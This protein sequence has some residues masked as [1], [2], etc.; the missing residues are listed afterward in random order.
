VLDIGHGN[1]HVRIGDSDLVEVQTIW[2]GNGNKRIE[3]VGSRSTINLGVGDSVIEHILG[4]AAVI[5]IDGGNNQVEFRP[6]GHSTTPGSAGSV[7]IGGN[8]NN[9]VSSSSDDP[10]LTITT[11]DG[12]DVVTLG[13]PGIV[14][15]N[16]GNDQ[17]SLLGNS[18]PLTIFLGDG[19]DRFVQRDDF[20]NP[21]TVF[22]GLGN[23][24]VEGHDADSA[25]FG[26]GG[27][28]TLI[29]G[30]GADLLNGGGGNDQLFGGGGA[31][32]LYGWSG[33]DT[34]DGGAGDDRLLGRDDD[35]VLHGG[36]GNDELLGGVGD[37]RLYAEA[38]D[39]QLFGEGGD[40]RLYADYSA[41][42]ATLHGGNGDDLLVTDDGLVDHLFGDAGTDAAVADNLD[43]R[44]GVESTR[45][46]DAPPDAEF[47]RLA[48]DGG[49]LKFKG[50]EAAE[51]VSMRVEGRQ[52][53]VT[54]GAETRAFDA[55]RVLRIELLGAGGD[56][57]LTLDPTVRFPASING[58]TGN[59]RVVGGSSNDTLE[60]FDGDDTLDAGAGDDTLYGGVGTDT[61]NGGA[62]LNTADYRSHESRLHI[63]LEGNPAAAA[64][65]QADRDAFSNIA[66]VLGGPS[67]DFIAGT[68]ANE[69]LVGGDLQDTLLG[70]GGNDDLQGQ[71]Y[72]D[73]IEGGAGD[74]HIDGG[75]QRDQLF[76]LAGNDR[77]LSNNDS[78]E[79]TVRGGDGDDS[80]DSDAFDDVIGVESIE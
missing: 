68:D 78:I 70:R 22:G 2:G 13:S 19:H 65:P 45:A 60:G 3:A 46:A 75:S 73:Y 43:V 58:G 6:R 5:N 51:T 37:D 53:L 52:V 48:L 38:G 62:G 31:D 36:T 40:D 64:H 21:Y 77:I 63:D 24:Y 35:D 59:D 33:D 28:D 34:L 72:E 79:D 44:D 55:G 32:R 16:G 61:V 27:K 80:A 69:T 26:E 50:T 20:T 8:G 71:D 18:G 67:S 11:G 23:D 74:D 76:G 15:T 14:R 66:V 17:V 30:D 29:G 7:T 9:H 25:F 1:D 12:D 42:E 47:E 41:G 10:S 57:V 39:D 56:D 49:L 4:G 54:I